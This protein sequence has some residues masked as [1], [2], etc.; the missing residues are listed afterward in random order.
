MIV[1]CNSAFQFGT[2]TLAATKTALKEGDALDDKVTLA[3][4]WI[5]EW[6]HLCN[7]CKLKTHISLD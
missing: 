3:Q 4:I 1:F 7:K 2:E 6:G 5:H